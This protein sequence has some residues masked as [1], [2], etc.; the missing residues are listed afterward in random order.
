MPV[1]ILLKAIGQTPEQI[2][3]TFFEF[4]TFHLSNKGVS[5]DIVPERLR[6]ETARFDLWTRPARSS[7]P[8][9][10]RITAKHIRDLGEASLKKIAVPEDFLIGRTLATNIVDSSTGEVLANAN[11]EITDSLLEKLID[12]GVG[13]IKTLFV[14]DLDRGAYIS[15]TLRADETADQWAARVAIYRMMRP[16]E[17]PTEDAVEALF[18]GLFYSAGTLRPVGR[19]P[20]EV[21]PSRV[22]RDEIEGPKARC[23]TTT[24]SA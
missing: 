18:N 17:P 12:A 5:F 14:N 8:K 4:D 19:G 24:S 13:D 21:Q 2:L 20:H 9:D 15:S 11:D 10:K 22:G 6:G 3:E 1:T 16:G 7:S 23:R